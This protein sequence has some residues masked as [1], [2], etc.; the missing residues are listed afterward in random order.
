MEALDARLDLVCGHGCSGTDQCGRTQQ[1]FLVAGMAD[2]GPCPIGWS[3]ADLPKTLAVLV[4]VLGVVLA[5]IFV[6]AD[7]D[8]KGRGALQP[9]SSGRCSQPGRR[10]R[11]V[12]QS[13][14][15]RSPR[16]KLLVELD[17]TDLDVRLQDVIGRA[18]QRCRPS[19]RRSRPPRAIRSLSEQRATAGSRRR[20]RRLAARGGLADG[21]ATAAQPARTADGHESRSTAR[22]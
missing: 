2:A 21:T 5:L 19:K 15:T 10:C 8:L 18:A 6:P 3:G 20:S 17:N 11:E 9:A 7:F 12:R 13:T 16:I 14:P 1:C 22:W 4:G